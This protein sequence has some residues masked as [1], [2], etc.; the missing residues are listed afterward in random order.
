M[1]SGGVGCDRIFIKSAIC[2]F[3][4]GESFHVDLVDSNNNVKN[5]R[6]TFVGGSSVVMMGHHVVD[7]GMFRLSNVCKELWHIKDFSSDLL[8]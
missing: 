8:V 3:L 7:T 1:T 6:Y 4:L 5:F 2:D